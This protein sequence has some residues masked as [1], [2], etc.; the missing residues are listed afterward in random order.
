MPLTYVENCADAIA[1]AGTRPEA[2]GQ[3]YNVVDDDLPTCSQYLRQYQRN[4]ES[5]RVLRL[6][7]FATRMLSKAVEAYSEW[8]KGQL[9]P[10]FTPY[11]TASTWG[12]NT[13]S[14]AKLKSI[15]WIPA[16]STKEGLRR[17]FASVRAEK[18]SA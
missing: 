9:P 4:V 1:Q 10:V 8:S 15:G 5:L 12:G 3:V 13:F 17:T 7:Y 2:S 18:A 11:K 6:P 16:V 14:N